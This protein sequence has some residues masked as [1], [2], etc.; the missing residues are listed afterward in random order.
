MSLFFVRS[1]TGLVY[2]I[3]LI[4]TETSPEKVC[5]QIQA[6]LPAFFQAT[7]FKVICEGKDLRFI[8]K[9]P[10]EMATVGPY[11]SSIAAIHVVGGKPSE[12]SA[13]MAPSL[14]ELVPV[15]TPLTNFL[16]TSSNAGPV[17]AP[18]LLPISQTKR[19]IKKLIGAKK[20][21]QDEARFK[22]KLLVRLDKFRQKG[23]V[24]SRLFTIN[25][26][27]DDITHELALLHVLKDLQDAETPS[28]RYCIAHGCGNFLAPDEEL[29]CK[30]CDN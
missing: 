28:P 10:G 6:Q 8:D 29:R 21:P 7:N 30:I 15:P 26:H 25:S 13:E 5:D 9:F 2:P 3:T 1:L 19:A 27:I 24:V 17:P 20:S 12:K 18:A 16:W 14:P 4:S 23:F 11:F 22:A